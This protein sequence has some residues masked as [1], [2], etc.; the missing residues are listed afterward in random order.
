MGSMDRPFVTYD[1]T[2]QFFQDQDWLW[3]ILPGFVGLQTTVTIARVTHP[4][5]HTS[6]RL[7]GIP[8][9]HPCRLENHKGLK[10]S[11]TEWHI[12]LDRISSRGVG[13]YHIRTAKDP[14]KCL[15]PKSNDENRVVLDLQ[16]WSGVWML[17][18]RTATGGQGWDIVHGYTGRR[19]VAN[20][21]GVLELTGLIHPTTHWDV[22][23]HHATVDE[24]R[25]HYWLPDFFA[26]TFVNRAPETP[27]ALEW[28]PFATTQH[29][30]MV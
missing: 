25:C 17:V 30:S 3:Y 2:S 24:H 1:Q 23:F 11:A 18:P 5:F 8:T 4:D 10:A 13:Y 20:A 6:Y 22:M 21:D 16:Q 29:V 12:T 9:D 28:M 14:S 19:L 15:Q 7:F 26:H 27:M